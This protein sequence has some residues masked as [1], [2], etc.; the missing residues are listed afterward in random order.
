MTT[1]QSTLDVTWRIEG[2]HIIAALARFTGDIGRAEDLASDASVEALSTW[3]DAGV[4][5]NAAAWLT[6]V[7]KRRAIDA[8]RR[9]ARLAERYAAM[10]HDLDEAERRDPTAEWEPVDDDVLRLVFIACHPVLSRESQVALTLRV[11]GGLT[12]TEIGRMLL[13]PVATVQARIT[14][15]KRTLSEARVPFE[16]PDPGELRARLGGVLSVVYLI[17]TEG[18]AA[19]SGDTWMRTD[20]AREALRLGRILSGL[21]PREP[22]VFALVA[23]MEFQ[24][25]RFAARTDAAGQPILLADQNRARWDH[26]QIRR[27][28]AALARADALGHGRGAYALQAAIA[29]CHAVAPSVEATD[30]ERI[31]VLYEALG[32]LAPN[33]IVDLNRAV[34]VSK[35]TGPAS[36]LRIVDELVAAGALKGSHLLPSVRGELLLQ[37]GRHDE[38]R[39][40]LERAASLTGNEREAEVLRGKAQ[41]LGPAHS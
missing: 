35:A 36:A 22:E 13:A 31:V 4:P 30:W 37:L 20:L 18:Y 17:F 14:R 34:A 38:A 15:A 29:E 33:P 32:R 28:S 41:R 12:T 10:A 19:T 21:M 6:A 24:A 3:P 40:E 11:V 23:L 8:W 27:G 5:R 39:A 25:S 16:S 1:V 9:D 2:A 26:A 7:A